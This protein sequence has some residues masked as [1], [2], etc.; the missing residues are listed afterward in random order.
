M[1]SQVQHSLKMAGVM[2]A[3]A[4]LGSFIESYTNVLQAI[5]VDPVWW[6][7]IGAAL[8]AA[9]RW[10]EGVRDGKRAAEGRLIPSDVAYSEVSFHRQLA[11]PNLR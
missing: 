1:N 3:I 7:I 11:D 10:F 4:A 8:T 9:V 6:P 2:M 5:G